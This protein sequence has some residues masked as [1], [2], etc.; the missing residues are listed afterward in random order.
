MQVKRGRYPQVDMIFCD[1]RK[2]ELA[3][4]AMG[5]FSTQCGRFSGAGFVFLMGGN[6]AFDAL[7]HARVG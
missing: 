4:K 6:L 7:F 1:A 3:I 2:A 5:D